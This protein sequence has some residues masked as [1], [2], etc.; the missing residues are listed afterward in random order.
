[1]GAKP[2]ERGQEPHKPTDQTHRQVRTLSGLGVRVNEICLVIEISKQTLYKYYA[3]D[4]ERGQVEA[5][6]RV[7][8]SLFNAATRPE[9]PNVVACIFW[10]KNRAGWKDVVE[11]V[12]REVMGGID[13]PPRPESADEWLQRRRLELDAMG[14]AAGA[15]NGRDPRKLD[16]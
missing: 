2:G 6:I 8:S 7:A 12:N 9:N 5:N 13:A 1:M 15:A 11:Q 16:S 14:T 10:L 3:A 4:V